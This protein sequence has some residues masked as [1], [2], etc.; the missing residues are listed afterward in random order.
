MFTDSFILRLV[1]V[2]LA[3]AGSVTYAQQKSQLPGDY[4]NKPIRLIVGTA[5]SGADIVGRIVAQGISD[6]LGQ[7]VIVENRGNATLGTVI[8]AQAPPDGYTLRLGGSSNWV[9][10]LL[11]KASNQRQTYDMVRDFS[12]VTLLVKDVGVLV[13]NPSVPVKSVKELIAL[14]KAKPGALNY[15]TFATGAS[16]H[17][18]TELFKSMAGVNLVWVPYNGSGAATAALFAGEVQV[19]ISTL[20]LAAPHMKSGKIR[21][22]AVTS[23]TPSVLAPGLPTVASDLPGFEMVGIFG[24]WAPAKTP[25]AIINRLN[26]E[27][28]RALNQPEVKGRFLNAGQEVVG[29]SPEQFDSFIKSDIAIAAKVIKDAGIK[30]N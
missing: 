15:A 12:P 24:I 27:M 17:L 18:G 3:S 25:R 7:P 21:A 13:V 5:G 8:A 29:S 14:A 26:L 20:A 22:L 4:P 30:V 2:V 9:F 28:V 11:E 23:A 19:L 10:S 1:L 6:P 16:G